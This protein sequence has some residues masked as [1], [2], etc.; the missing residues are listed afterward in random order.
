[1][2]EITTTMNLTYTNINELYLY[3]QPSIMDVQYIWAKSSGIQ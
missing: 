2:I 3:E 1:M